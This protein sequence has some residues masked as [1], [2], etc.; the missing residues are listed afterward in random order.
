MLAQL[1][2]QASPRAAGVPDIW[3]GNATWR[4]G[5]SL[6]CCDL[7][8]EAALDELRVAEDLVEREHR[9]RADVGLMQER[10]PLGAGARP[11]QLAKLRLDPIAIGALDVV[12]RPEILAARTSRQKFA[13]N[14]GSSAPSV[15]W[16][17]S[18]A[19]YTP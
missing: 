7:R 15:T 1:R 16:P 4:T 17:P 8:E 19:S 2:R 14:W 5:P 9:A 10:D 18:A 13:Q 12:E 11:E 3:T 6:G